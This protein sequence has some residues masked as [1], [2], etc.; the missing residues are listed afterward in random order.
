MTVEG[1]RSAAYESAEVRAVVA[2]VGVL[3]QAGRFDEARQLLA[4]LIADD[5]DNSMLWQLMAVAHY[6]AEK[7]SE[8]QDAVTRAIALDP[9][10]A[11]SYL[12]FAKILI[13]ADCVGEGI[14][15]A[16]RAIEIEPDLVE[17]HVLVSTA[18]GQL[19]YG[20]DRALWHGMRARD[21]EP[22]SAQAHYAVGA[23]LMIGDSRRAAK[24]A[25][26]PLHAALSIDPQLSHVWNHLA[27]AH[28]RRAR[29]VRAVRGFVTALQL[30]PQSEVAAH[31][32]PLAVWLLVIRGRWWALGL[33]FF[34][35][36]TAV[37]ALELD[38]ESAVAGSAAHTVGALLIAG[39][40]WWV[41]VHRLLRVFPADMRLAAKGVLRRDRLV[42]PAWLGQA[43]AL[44]WQ[45]AT[46]AVPWWN[47]AMIAVCMWVSM[48]GM[49]VGTAISRVQ[50][51]KV[52]K[53]RQDERHRAWSAAVSAPQP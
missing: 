24:Q 40:A 53:A 12:L 44:A 30:D 20:R 42:R 43:W 34:T 45:I 3:L 4:S 33:L 2:R 25:Y 19:N 29:S 17:A 1:K 28:L 16:M 27:I 18:L 31:N 26:A 35:A 52:R 41:L 38:A 39:A 48:L 22:N 21:L 8:A 7:Y 14:Q 13:S 47:P 5:P 32:L 10:N 37:V 6:G 11:H 9:D 49:W 50:I 51:G 46:V 36:P 23:A 15:R